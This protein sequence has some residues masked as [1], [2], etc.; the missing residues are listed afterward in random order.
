M[1]KITTFILLVMGA[2]S[3]QAQ[4][5]PLRFVDNNGNEVADGSVLDLTEVEDLGF[6]DVQISSGLF[7]ENLTSEDVVCGSEYSITALPNGAFQTCFPTNCVMRE[8]TGS[9]TSE[10]GTLT[11]HEKKSIQTEWLP[12]D[13]GTAVAE[14]QLLRYKLNPVTQK[15]AIDARGPKVTL[16]FI[17]NPTGELNTFS[18]FQVVSTTYHTLD[19]QCVS[20]PT[21]G[22]HIVRI[23]YTDGTVKTLKQNY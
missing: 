18:D 9:W 17:F 13:P 23:V 7:V 8:T 6:G 21:R 20:S 3:I 4:D 19:G 12:Y 10:T 22:L 1:K 14:F 15:Y 11:A 2:L 5:F 16:R